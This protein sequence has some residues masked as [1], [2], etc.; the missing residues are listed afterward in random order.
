MAKPRKK[1]SAK[2][3]QPVESLAVDLSIPPW[4]LAGMMRAAGWAEGKQVTA[5]EFADALQRFRS[6]RV[7]G[8][9]I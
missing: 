5:D 7:G 6:R 9:K 8:G 3:L 4:E 1:A 2:D